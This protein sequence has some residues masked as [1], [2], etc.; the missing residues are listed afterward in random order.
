[1]L[2]E[3]V[4]H[5]LGIITGIAI[6]EIILHIP[7]IKKW[8]NQRR[9]KNIEKEKTQIIK[10]QQKDHATFRQAAEKTKRPETYEEFRARR[11]AEQAK[12]MKDDQGGFIDLAA[13]VKLP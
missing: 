11:L 7:P 2:M 5:A 8:Y 13:E 12:K 6:V 9:L 3:W 1:M 4:Q 10:E